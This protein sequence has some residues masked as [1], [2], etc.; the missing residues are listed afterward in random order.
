MGH[1]D[2][3]SVEQ[4]FRW[5]DVIVLP[6]IEASQ[7]GVLQV[8]TAF[9]IPPVATRVGGLTDVIADHV[10]GLLVTPRD[11]RSL[12]AGLQELLTNSSLRARV[13]ANVQAD[14]GN[15]FSWSTIG[16]RTLGIYRQVINGFEMQTRA[17]SHKADAKAAS[18]AENVL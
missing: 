14:R 12:A 9:A 4:L 15:R 1:Q 17:S 11:P 2:D 3:A 7:S 8:A 5:A 13:I 10:N 18:S 16:I 6:Y